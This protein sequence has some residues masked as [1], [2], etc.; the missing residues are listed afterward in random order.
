[1]LAQDSLKD[2]GNLQAQ[3]SLKPQGNLQ[4]Q[5]SLKHEG[6]LQTQAKLLAQISLKSQGN[7]QV[8]ANHHPRDHHNMSAQANNQ[9]LFVMI[10]QTLEDFNKLK[11]ATEEAGENV[12]GEKEM[13]L[14]L[15][16][17]GKSRKRYGKRRRIN[18]NRREKKP[19][20]MG[21][22]IYIDDTS[23][24]QTLNVRVQPI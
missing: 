16:Q 18:I 21:F 14:Q 9:L 15:L 23:G 24:I 19:K 7:V 1:M 20:T 22:G 12:G 8:L 3:V 5:V 10:L 4:A 2:Q 11:E 13:I 17:K 6:N